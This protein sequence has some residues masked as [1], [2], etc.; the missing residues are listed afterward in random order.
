M[1]VPLMLSLDPEGTSKTSESQ[2]ET[3]LKPQIH[4]QK[5]HSS[6]NG[7]RTLPIATRVRPRPDTKSE[8]DCQA[9][10]KD[11]RKRKS[12]RKSRITGQDDESPLYE[13]TLYYPHNRACTIYRSRE[14]FS[15]LRTGLHSRSSSTAPQPLATPPLDNTTETEADPKEVARWD[16]LLRKAIER[17]AKN[18]HGRYSVEWFLRRRLGDCER[19][20][21][22]K[23]TGLPT[24]TTRR[25]KI[26]QPNN[27]DDETKT[28]DRR[29]GKQED[30]VEN[31]DRSDE[32][33]SAADDICL[34]D[35][36]EEEKD[37]NSKQSQEDGADEVAKGECVD[38]EET[39]DN[40]GKPS[41]EEEDEADDNS[42][43]ST[44]AARPKG[45][46]FTEVVFGLD[47]LP[48][49]PFKPIPDLGKL[50]GS[51]LAKRRKNK[52]KLEDTGRSKRDNAYDTEEAHQGSI[53]DA[54]IST[55]NSAL[56]IG[57]LESSS[58]EGTM[59]L[60]PTSSSGGEMS[61]GDPRPNSAMM[62][63]LMFSRR[64]SDTDLGQK[65]FS[66]HDLDDKWHQH[67]MIRD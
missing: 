50:A 24:C 34:H 60:T 62:Y 67:T 35:T 27:M 65:F 55:L 37:G 26:K 3:R 51:S 42:S 19:M 14:D 4:T 5:N 61:P 17:F 52:L 12:K 30:K 31:T 47:S 53:D 28:T 22:G 33:A 56:E 57:T 7:T 66:L 48:V 38:D 18:G 36:D 6:Y 49:E 10:Y 23:G 45:K 21:S 41:N 39:H 11:Q 46:Q 32:E 64:A 58:S 29:K 54:E 16:S 13:V 40:N 63:M 43:D 8:H 44:K 20:A 9:Q 59:V 1:L 2:P 25:V 15:L